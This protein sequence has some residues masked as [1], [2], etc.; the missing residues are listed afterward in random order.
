MP[1][2]RKKAQNFSS[3]VSGTP[4]ACADADRPDE[5]SNA[6]KDGDRDRSESRRHDADAANNRDQR[7]DQQQRRKAELERSGH[8]G[9]VCGETTA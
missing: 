4:S 2:D 1:A 3:R 6:D 8:C 9:L 5:P 7:H